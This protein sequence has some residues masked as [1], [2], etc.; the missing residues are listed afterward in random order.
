MYFWQFAELTKT[1]S[2]RTSDCFLAIL[3]IGSKYTWKLFWTDETVKKLSK[4]TNKKKHV[5]IM[6]NIVEKWLD[7]E[8][9]SYQKLKKEL[10]RENLS[11]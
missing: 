6:S 1:Y 8:I 7:C 3:P 4:K 11:P 2:V 9:M 5:K 10:I